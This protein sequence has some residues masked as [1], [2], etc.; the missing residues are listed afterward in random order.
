MKS[1]ERE[2]AGVSCGTRCANRVVPLARSG[3]K[4]GSARAVSSIERLSHGSRVRVIIS[5]LRF[6]HVI[7]RYRRSGAKA[8][9]TPAVLPC[10][11]LRQPG[12]I[13]RL[14]KVDPLA[15]IWSRCLMHPAPPS[16]SLPREAL[17]SW[18]G[19]KFF[20]QRKAAPTQPILQH[21]YGRRCFAVLAVVERC[22]RL[23]VDASARILDILAIKSGELSA[24]GLVVGLCISRDRRRED[25]RHK[26][27]ENAFHEMP[28]KKGRRPTSGVCL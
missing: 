18:L 12:A 19:R 4:S 1:A 8:D 6:P 26:E 13:R 27:Q 2:H 9:F 23:D 22:Q 7:P 14:A 3:A 28:D 15:E 21:R 20:R 24:I 10:G 16:R 11:D 17:C 25:R 5:Q